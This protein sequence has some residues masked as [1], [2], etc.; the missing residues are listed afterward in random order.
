MAGRLRTAQSDRGRQQK[1][2]IEAAVSTQ[3]KKNR[4]GDGRQLVSADALVTS[5]SVRLEY[6]RSTFTA[7]ADRRTTN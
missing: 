2:K 5:L 6:A 4:A 1:R 7:S 3:K